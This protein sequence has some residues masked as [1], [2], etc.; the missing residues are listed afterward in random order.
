MSLVAK[1]LL[2]APYT[3]AG[4]VNTYVYAGNRTSFTAVFTAIFQFQHY[5]GLHIA[6]MPSIVMLV[7]FPGDICA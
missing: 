5:S 4:P 6:W 7:F 1:K 2:H 3:D